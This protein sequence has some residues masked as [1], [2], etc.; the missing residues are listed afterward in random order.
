MPTAHVDRFVLDRLPPPELLPE[1]RFDRPEFHYP[2]RLNAGAELI[3]RAVAAGWRAR[4][5][6]VFPDGVWTYAELAKAANQLASVLREDFALEPG[7]R[8][9]L[10]GMNGPMLSAL[11][12]AVLKAG[13]VVVVTMP[14]LRARELSFVLEK[15]R[16]DLALCEGALVDELAQAVAATGQAR[17][18]A[19]SR[20]GR[21]QETEI[22]RRMRDKPES[23]A[24]VETRASDPALLAFTSGT[25]GH[26]KATV[27]FHR[28]VLAI[29]DA[30]PRS[31]LGVQMGDRFLCSAPMAF[32]F[33]LGGQ[34]VFPLRYG[35][36]SVL[37]PACTPDQ[38]L[39]AVSEYRPSI[40]MTAPTAYRAMTEGAER[41]DLSHVRHCVSA[42]EHLPAATLEAWRR[43]TDHG[44]ING[45]GSTEMLHIFLSSPVGEAKPGATGTAIRGYTACVLN[46]DDAPATP[47][48]VGRLAVKGP[49]G[50]RYLDDERQANYVRRGWNVTGDA[51]TMDEDGCFWFQSRTDDM[52]VSAGYNISGFEVEEAM[53]RH[54][55][56]AE[57]AVVGAAD[58]A[59]GQVVKAF[60]V[61]KAG[62]QR[63]EALKREIQDFVKRDIA[64][65]KYPR[66]IEFL[67]ALPRNAS[68]KVQRYLL[69]DRASIAS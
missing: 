68:G 22:E 61:A 33:G 6:I 2:E 57:C 43:A 32:T 40:L 54:P 36:S 53:L 15:S 13:C 67:D 34:L 48:E 66:A 59:R 26:P 7:A 23:F 3:D 30:F 51:C 28:D 38:L 45:L 5:A 27:H 47:G 62:H 17:I 16:I 10:R 60:V 1:F 56:I 55:A 12:L 69:R 39:D 35:G 44:I 4:T 19:Y 50:C 11:W 31:I 41:R 24:A 14:L 52:I 21:S 29:A 25:T 8:V 65:F 46:E 9:L 20:D 42:G 49:T 63:S 37:L 18:A 58:E 64:P